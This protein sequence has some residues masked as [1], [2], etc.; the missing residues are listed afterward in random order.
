MTAAV[1]KCSSKYCCNCCSFAREAG[2]PALCGSRTRV[3]WT[4][5]E[6]GPFCS[7]V[8]LRPRYFWWC[9]D[10]SCCSNQ[11]CAPHRRSVFFVLAFFVSMLPS[12]NS[13][14]D[15]GNT[16]PVPRHL[17]QDLPQRFQSG[18]Q[19]DSQVFGGA[20]ERRYFPNIVGCSSFLAGTLVDRSTAWR[21]SVAES[22]FTRIS[23][24]ILL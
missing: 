18:R 15:R 12:F 21:A 6:G 19:R 14:S 10:A 3:G 16:P 1:S 2:R 4:H 13:T 8:V 17:G 11:T 5:F 7:G 24:Y 20:G 9:S 22:T 23:I